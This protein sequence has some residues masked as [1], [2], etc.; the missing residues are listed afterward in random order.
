MPYHLN[1]PDNKLTIEKI[2]AVY[3]MLQ[4]SSLDDVV[5]AK[6]L[7]HKLHQARESMRVL[8]E[9][10]GKSAEEISKAFENL[11]TTYALTAP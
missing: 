1:T 4:N 7:E 2:E 11:I 3:K 6:E 8:I 9:A 5:L 10:R